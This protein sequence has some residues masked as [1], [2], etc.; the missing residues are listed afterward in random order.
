M[1]SRVHIAADVAKEV[2]Q[3]Y[4]DGWDTDENRGY[5]NRKLQFRAKTPVSP[6]E[7]ARIM[8]KA[9]PGGTTNSR[10]SY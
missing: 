2:M 6:D 10:Q 7:A 9:C 4:S 5:Q 8:A 3:A 1:F